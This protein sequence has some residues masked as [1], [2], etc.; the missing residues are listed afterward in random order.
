[1][2]K[3]HSSRDGQRDLACARDGACLGV[4]IHAGADD[5]CVADAPWMLVR[6]PSCASSGG[7]VPILVASYTS[8]S[9]KFVFFCPAACGGRVEGRWRGRRRLWL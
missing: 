3:E 9:A 5:G 2:R 1:M 4:G 6:E 8:N 7:E